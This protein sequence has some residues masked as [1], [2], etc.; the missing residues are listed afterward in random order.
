M[1][2]LGKAYTDNTLQEQMRK[3]RMD[4]IASSHRDD[5]VERQSCTLCRIC[6]LGLQLKA[7]DGVLRAKDLKR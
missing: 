6:S 5:S 2:K 7:V 4:G 3:E 1:I